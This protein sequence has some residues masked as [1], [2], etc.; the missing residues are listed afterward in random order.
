MLLQRAPLSCS[1]PSALPQR[2]PSPLQHRA[3]SAYHLVVAGK[4]RLT[5]A[6]WVVWVVLSITSKP[7]CCNM[8]YC[9]SSGSRPQ[10]R[11]PNLAFFLRRD[12]ETCLRCLDS[13]SCKCCAI[14]ALKPADTSE[15]PGIML[16]SLLLSQLHLP[17]Q[18]CAVPSKTP[19]LHRPWHSSTSLLHR[20]RIQ[21]GS[22]SSLGLHGRQARCAHDMHVP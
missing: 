1:S 4:S 14:T 21:S 2:D 3:S 9:C 5:V 20:A 22:R 7:L 17:T 8:P 18:V 19:H 10:N 11:P 13:S 12:P 6:V 16:L 15:P